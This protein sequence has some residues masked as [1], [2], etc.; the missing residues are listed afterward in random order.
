MSFP[1]RPWWRQALRPQ[2][3]VPVFLSLALLA[4]A[5]SI[6]D[7]PEVADRI[8]RIDFTTGLTVFGL[9]CTYLFLK[10]LQFRLL[11]K[12]MGIRPNWR[13]FVLAFAVGE[14]TLPIPSG[15]YVQNYVLR[16]LGAAGFAHSAAATT[17]A[18]VIEAGVA[19]TIL[20]IAGVPSWQGFRLAPIALVLAAA[21]LFTALIRSRRVRRLAEGLADRRYVGKLARAALDLARGV[22]SAATPGTLGPAFL[23]GVAYLSTLVVSLWVVGHG[24]GILRL[25]LVESASMYFFSLATAL[26]LGGILAQLGVLE[27][28][29]I[30]VAEAWGYNLSD[31]LAMFLAFRIF[32]M[33]SI[34]LV[35]GA[36]VLA[37]WREFR[38]SGNGS[39]KVVD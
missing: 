31:A 12:G 32:W 1:R 38:S 19:S 20:A 4:F 28:A 16:H 13:H 33:A 3:I 24:V 5:L 22:R 15:V 35:S 23:L 30:G 18:L 25:S 26:L 2:V 14:M 36:G 29:G 34:W 21:A 17:L 9:A 7:L 6:S 8:A 37:L 27:V 39:Q 10:S 11:L